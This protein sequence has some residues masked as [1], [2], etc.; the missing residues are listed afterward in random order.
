MVRNQG[1]SAGHAVHD[2]SSRSF[3]SRNGNRKRR[4]PT[5]LDNHS[6]PKVKIVVNSNTAQNEQEI[7][8]VPVDLQQAVLDMFRCALLGVLDDATSATSMKSLVQEVKGHLYN[9][10]FVRAFGSE[11][12]LEV[13]A[14]RWSASRALGYIDVFTKALEAL[15]DRR[16]VRPGAAADK[17]L[18][19]N[20]NLPL[21]PSSPSNE[22]ES[23]KIVCLGGGGGAELCGLVAASNLLDLDTRLEIV[24]VDS[25]DWS[26]VL[27]K[28]QTTLKSMSVLSQAGPAGTETLSTDATMSTAGLRTTFQRLDIL[29]QGERS[30]SFDSSIGGA[31]MIIL[32]FTLNELYSTS[33]SKTQ[34]FLLNLTISAKP[35][36][37][38]LI[39]DSPG[40]YSSVT[41]NG[42]EKQYPMQWLLEHTLLTSAPKALAPEPEGGDSESVNPHGGADAKLLR[43]PRLWDCIEATDSR[44]FRLP[45]NLKY[46]LEL[47]NMRYQM[48]LW[49]RL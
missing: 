22:A 28:L 6:K 23:T 31:D 11:E 12:Y 8:I 44:W 3:P 46:P 30:H 17:L 49:R 25:G 16:S 35:G 19:R 10:D 21:G 40:S 27:Q 26:K 13:Y 38:L 15:A 14:A 47:E 41:L 34:K 4:G 37:L 2:S 48:S 33:I 42:S 39:I 7:A 1:S 24:M 29:N 45:P 20:I 43:P 32:A 9:R 18:A 5:N 36:S